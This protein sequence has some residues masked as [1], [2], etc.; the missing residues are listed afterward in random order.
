MSNNKVEGGAGGGGGVLKLTNLLDPL[1]PF[2]MQLHQYA[3]STP[4]VNT[5]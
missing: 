2:P 1:R 3:K 5:P 4:S